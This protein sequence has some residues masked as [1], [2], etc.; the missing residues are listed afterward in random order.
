M[1]IKLYTAVF[2]AI[3]VLASG[4]MASANNVDG[5]WS[6]VANWPLISIHAALTPDKRVLTYGTDGVGTQTGYFIYDVWDPTAGL[7]GGHM[8]LNNLTTTD[9]FCSAAIILPQSGEILTIGGDNW[10]GSDT[11][12]TGNNNSNIFDYSNNTLTP[13][14]NMNR[15]PMVLRISSRVEW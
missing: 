12:N 15:P 8:T 11:T 14:A 7:G 10:T 4:G 5:A 2:F 1:S 9:L 13:S 3:C 6:P